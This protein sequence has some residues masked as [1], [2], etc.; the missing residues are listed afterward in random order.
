MRGRLSGP[1]SR[2]WCCCSCSIS[3][4]NFRHITTVT[5]SP[6]ASQSPP[7]LSLTTSPS[8]SLHMSILIIMA[9]LCAMPLSPISPS[10]HTLSQHYSI[11]SGLGGSGHSLLTLTLT[12][13]LLPPHLHQHYV[14]FDFRPNADNFGITD[15]CK[16][17]IKKQLSFI[18]K[19]DI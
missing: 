6:S 18:K 9:L 5:P 16:A 17:D 15:D 1:T 12:F 19:F 4:A 7:I 3:T 14:L 13:N 10:P 11:A 2:L 8:S